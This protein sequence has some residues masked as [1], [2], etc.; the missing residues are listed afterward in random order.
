MELVAHRLIDDFS[1]HYWVHVYAFNYYESPIVNLTK[2][3][4]KVRRATE[5][6]LRTPSQYQPLLY[7]NSQFMGCAAKLEKKPDKMYFKLLCAM[8]QMRN[9]WDPLFPKPTGRPC[10]ND[11]DCR[12][13][14]R[15]L[16]CEAKLG[17]CFAPF[18]SNYWI[19]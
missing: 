11:G 10:K 15:N 2:W 18:D 5:I 1:K 3:R 12:P 6:W 8:D 7:P 13:L 19:A 9:V 14:G 17:L 16:R 4:L